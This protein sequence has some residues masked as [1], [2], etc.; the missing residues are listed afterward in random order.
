MGSCCLQRRQGRLAGLAPRTRGSPSYRPCL[1]QG[2]ETAAS[3]VLP[4]LTKK[5][6]LKGAP[7]R[8]RAATCPGT[9]A[10]HGARAGTNTGS[11]NRLTPRHQRAGPRRSRTPRA[12]KRCGPASGRGPGPLT[13]PLRHLLSLPPPRRRRRQ[14]AAPPLGHDTVR[15]AGPLRAARPWLARPLAGRG[16]TAASG[17]G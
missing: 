13:L 14:R 6:R 8:K 12:P 7:S 4:H 17:S 1:T 10:R 9:A 15:P 11:R 3:R 2:K 16:G 5:L